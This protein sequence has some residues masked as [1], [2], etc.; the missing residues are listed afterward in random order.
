MSDPQTIQQ[1]LQAEKTAIEGMTD[2]TEAS[3]AGA[4][5]QLKLAAMKGDAAA[6]GNLAKVQKSLDDYRSGRGMVEWFRNSTKAAEWLIEQGYLKKKGGGLLTQDAARK[7]VDTLRRDPVRGYNAT[8][9]RRAADNEY[10]SAS[11]ISSGPLTL[12]PESK[13][14][15]EQLQAEILRKNR[16]DADKK[17]M[18]VEELRRDLDKRWLHRDDAIENLA[19]I[20]AAVQQAL[21]HAIHVGSEAIIL[22]AGGDHNRA[23]EV[24]DAIQ[25]YII[26]KA[27]NEVSAAG[28]IH[29]I[30][31]GENEEI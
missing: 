26:A 11:K 25:E 21:D 20:W 28:K 31:K 22:A 4:C 3:L 16:A 18:E 12:D 5:L 19:A 24:E 1:Q 7:F 14:L 6:A 29:V 13:S 10:G 23:N 15:G 17:E 8:L 30:F 27:F 2:T 9:V